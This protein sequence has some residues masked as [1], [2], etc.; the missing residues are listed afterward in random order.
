MKKYIKEIKK[1]LLNEKNDIL[2][3]LLLGFAVFFTYSILTYSYTYSMTIKD[4][5]SEN[6]IRFHVLANSDSYEDQQLKIYIKDMILKKYKEDLLKNTTKEEAI[7]FF[8]NN[9]KEIE[10]YAKELV[11]EKGF[12]YNVTCELQYTD[13]PTKTYKDITLPKGEY[14]AFRVLIGDHTGKNFWCVLYP[15]LCYVDAVDTENFE[16]SKEKLKQS[17]TNDEY[18]LISETS[19]PDVHVKFKILEFWNN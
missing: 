11:K 4:D 13:F 14:L 1:I 6:L 7:V 2:I 15:P 9:T 16:N 19:K 12:D 18:I 17:I 8:T 5:I 3:S 10:N